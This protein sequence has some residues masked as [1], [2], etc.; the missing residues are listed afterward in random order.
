MLVDV[1]DCELTVGNTSYEP[2]RW[3]IRS[4]GHRDSSCR[5]SKGVRMRDPETREALPRYHE[6]AYE[7][8]DPPGGEG[9]RP[10]TK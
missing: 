3:G 5:A 8:N 7:V 1:D 4:G 6:L 2:W 10:K 9:W